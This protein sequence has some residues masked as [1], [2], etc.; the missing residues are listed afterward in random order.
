M[1]RVN[2]FMPSGLFYLFLWTGPSC[3]F[4]FEGVSGL[5]LVLPFII[6]ILVLN[7]NTVDPDQT[8]HYAASDLNLD[9]LPASFLGI[10]G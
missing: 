4:P 9:C 2:P 6:E 5:F 8:P 3:P 7:A 10:M 1:T